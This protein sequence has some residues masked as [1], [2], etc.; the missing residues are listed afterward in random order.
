MN[1]KPCGK[2]HKE[3]E[4]STTV[5]TVMDP[6]LQSFGFGRPHVKV[7]CWIE[8]GKEGST[9]QKIYFNIRMSCMKA[10]LTENPGAPS[11]PVATKTVTPIKASFISSA[12]V[13]EM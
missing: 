4:L 11:S 2:K 10:Y 8:V 13:V 9:G 1:N 6:H 7:V 3:V 5:S 12:S